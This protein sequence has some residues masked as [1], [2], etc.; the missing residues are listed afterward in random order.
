MVENLDDR[1]GIFGAR[2]PYFE[3]HFRRPFILIKEYATGLFEGAVGHS[4][5][6]PSRL[7]SGQNISQRDICGRPVFG[8]SGF[9]ERRPH[10]WHNS[11]VA[12]PHINVSTRTM[13]ACPAS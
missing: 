1:L 6:K 8:L 7:K 9:C 2:F 5:Q 13:V 11:I 3:C 4:L 10:V 12:W